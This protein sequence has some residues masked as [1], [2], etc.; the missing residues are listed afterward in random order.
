MIRLLALAICPNTLGHSKK[1]LS[2]DL[3]DGRG[4][5]GTWAD[6]DGQPRV[7]ADRACHAVR[8]ATGQQRA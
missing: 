2:A 6:A 3:T 1:Q 7:F 5:V 8:N 4:P